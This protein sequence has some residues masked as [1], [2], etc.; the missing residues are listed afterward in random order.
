MTREL[1]WLTLTVGVTALMPFPYV[2]SRIGVRGLAG[3]MANPRAT[4]API[5]EWAQR[6]QKAH[7]N[8]VENLV[9]FAPAILVVQALNLGNATTAFAAALYFFCRVAHYV[10]Y[11]AGIPGVRTLAFFGGW[12]GTGILVLRAL[13]VL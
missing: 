12:A 1:F 13:G 5:P 2:M 4:D 9:L 8:A 11:A 10:V 3:T 7:A 6:A